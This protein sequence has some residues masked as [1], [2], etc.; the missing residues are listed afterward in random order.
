MVNSRLYFDTRR[1]DKEGKYPL[2]IY[3]TKNGETA[4]MAMG[5]S[6]YPSQWK[7][8]KVIEHPDM[9]D[10]NS[11]ITERM[12]NVERAIRNLERDEKLVGKT[13]KQALVLIQEYLDPDIAER[14]AAEKKQKHIEENSFARYFRHRIAAINN[15]G[16]RGLYQD[17]YDKL[18]AFCQSKDIDFLAISFSEITKDFLTSFEAFCLTTQRQ[19]TAS[20]HLRDIRAVMNAAIDENL[21]TN[22]PFRKFKIKK[23]ESRDK[24]YSAAELRTLFNYPCYEGGQQ[25]AVDMFKLMFC[26]IGINCRDMAELGKEDRGR[27]VYN[28]NKT[29]KLYNIKLQPEA[30]EIINKYKGENHLLNILERVPNY[31]TYFNRM[32]KSLKKVGLVRESGKK[33]SGEALFPRMCTG[34]ARTSWGTIAQEELGIGRDTIAAALGHN[35]IDVTTTYLRTDWRKKVDDANRKVLDWVFYGKRKKGSK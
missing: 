21:T 19:N 6:L 32:G 24:S 26:L 34:S 8:G 3:I 15:A 22:Y 16:T 28:R 1:A 23:E 35:T 9:R 2:R 18:S 27:V 10:L 4:S 7:D 17:T 14:H 20:R 33:N 13:A 12:V 25:E 30:I 11:F 31:K 5:I 29:G